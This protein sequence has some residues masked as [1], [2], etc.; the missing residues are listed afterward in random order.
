MISPDL[1]SKALC[2]FQAKPSADRSALI[3]ASAFSEPCSAKSQMT[4][5]PAVPPIRRRPE[6]AHS[7]TFLIA[8]RGSSLYGSK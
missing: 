6:A 7:E 1:T 5:W 2:P 4:T 8:R 3:T